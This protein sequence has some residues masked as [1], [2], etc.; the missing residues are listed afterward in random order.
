[1]DCN[2]LIRCR[3]F[4]IELMLH[5]IYW[6]FDAFWFL[7]IENF[8]IFWKDISYQIS[9]YKPTKFTAKLYTNRVKFKF[10]L[11]YL[12]LNKKTIHRNNTKIPLIKS[13]CKQIVFSLKK[14]SF[15]ASFFRFCNR[16]WGVNNV[17]WLILV[18]PVCESI[19]DVRISYQT[20]GII[21]SFYDSVYTSNFIH[22]SEGGLCCVCVALAIDRWMCLS[23]TCV[24]K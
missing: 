5:P 18:S 6:Y 3:Y 9:R 17:E 23:N 22:L 20:N 14:I 16:K 15:A 13:N 4:H 19:C 10:S 8:F 24:F 12:L 11:L 1:M 21:L 2:N 7:A